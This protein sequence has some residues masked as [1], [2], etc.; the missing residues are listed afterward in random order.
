MTSVW[1]NS[2]TGLMVPHDLTLGSVGSGWN[3]EPAELGPSSARDRL[4]QNLLYGDDVLALPKPEF[5][6]DGL[7]QRDSLALLYGPSGIA[8]TFLGL[9]LGLHIAGGTAWHERS[10]MQGPILYV[11]AEGAYSLGPR[12]RSWL[13]HEE[14]ATTGPTFWLSMA[15]SL[16]VREEVDALVELVAHLR[17]KLIVIDTL[18]RCL[19]GGD[20]NSPRDMSTAVD[21]LDRLRRATKAC[22]CAI[23]H[24][25]KDRSAGARG[26]TALKGAIDTEIECTGSSAHLTL[27][28][29]KQRN[30]PEGRVGSFRLETVGESCVIVPTGGAAAETSSMES[31][32][33]SK[34]LHTLLD[35]D[36]GDGVPA[37][38]WLKAT[39]DIA[40]STFYRQLKKLVEKGAVVN[41]GTQSKPRYSLSPSY[42]WALT[43]TP[44]TLSETVTE[45]PA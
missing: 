22:V 36:M 15:P 4:Y 45:A 42:N 16:I 1:T 6:V 21:S 11:V 24:T 9:D 35:I 14:S 28:L 3:D 13:E 5:V 32:D 12:I 19:A 30:G 39:E 25:G 17:P 29:T 41:I 20:E 37:T 7:L 2:R 44:K 40:E 43:V 34:M 10:V 33:A 38:R 8:K 18:A 27:E 26:H 31:K 23:H